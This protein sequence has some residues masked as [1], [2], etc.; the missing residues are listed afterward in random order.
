MQRI[1]RFQEIAM[2]DEKREYFSMADVAKRYGVEKSTVSRWIDE[3]F[4]P[5]SEKMGP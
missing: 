1:E 2:N 5:G 4:L 3:N